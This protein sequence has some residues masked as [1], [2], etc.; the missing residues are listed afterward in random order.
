[1]GPKQLE[2]QLTTAQKD[3]IING[4]SKRIISRLYIKNDERR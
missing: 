2:K 3:Y 4:T 1:M